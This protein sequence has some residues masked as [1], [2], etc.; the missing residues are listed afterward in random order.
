M[1]QVGKFAA[2]N[3]PTLVSKQQVDEVIDEL[4]PQSI[5]GKEIGRG[6]KVIGGYSV[7]YVLYEHVFH[8]RIM[9][10]AAPP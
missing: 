5:R 2:S 8:L 1:D 6:R 3:Y 4:V 10:A 9:R 7:S